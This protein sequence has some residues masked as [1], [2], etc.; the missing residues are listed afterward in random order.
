MWAEAEHSVHA[1]QTAVGGEEGTS[2]GQACTSVEQPSAAAD[3]EAP[4]PAGTRRPRTCIY[5]IALNERKRVQ[6]FMDACKVGSARP[7]AF[8]CCSMRLQGLPHTP[9]P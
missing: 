7:V 4:L 1:V 5:A 8:V 6:S 9:A 3:L 2:M